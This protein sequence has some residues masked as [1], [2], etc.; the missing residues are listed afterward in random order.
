MLF[1]SKYLSE[2]L[3][4]YLLWLQW[5]WK[6]NHFT[7]YIATVLLVSAL[8]HNYFFHRIFRW[9]NCN[10]VS[11]WWWYG[12]KFVAYFLG[13]PCRPCSIWLEVVGTPIVR[14]YA[15][16]KLWSYDKCR[17][18]VTCIYSV[19]EWRLSV[20]GPL[21]RSMVGD[22]S[23]K[24]LRRTRAVSAGVAIRAVFGLLQHVALSALYLDQQF[25][26]G[27]NNY[28]RCMKCWIELST[29]VINLLAKT[30]EQSEMVSS[31]GLGLEWGAP[32]RLKNIVTLAESCIRRFDCM[33][34]RYVNCMTVRLKYVHD[35]TELGHCWLKTAS[36]H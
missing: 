20:H 24:T 12:Q 3:I 30:T 27:E 17:T 21:E 14:Q 28:T 16:K 19:Y 25:A 34:L 33:W 4:T 10:S 2:R 32:L 15:H 31:Y 23:R 36:L 35:D 11:I 22:K 29:F 9:K 1:Q 18:T 6:K 13:P 8:L 7:T 26:L 5:F